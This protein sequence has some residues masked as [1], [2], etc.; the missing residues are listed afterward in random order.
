M[1][2][3]LMG[4]DLGGK[5]G[6]CL[7]L[8]VESG[9]AV[10]TC[11][12]WQQ[13][14]TAGF[15]YDLDT[16]EVWRF[17]GEAAR[18]AM[19]KV[20]ARLQDVLAVSTTGMRHGS[21]V[22]DAGGEVLLA[23]QTRDVR[24]AMHGLQLAAERG[25]EFHQRTGHFPAPLFTTS[26]LLWMA[27]S[28][29]ELLGRA[30]A[31]LG[32]SDWL[33]YRLSGKIVAEPS[34]AS[35][36]GLFE[37]GA[38]RWADD[39]IRSLGLPRQL[40]P[41]VVSSGTV[42]GPLGKDAAA[43]LGLQPGIPVV[44]G[45]GDTQCGLLGAGVVDSGQM[46]I[47]AGS[48][49][50]LQWVLE[51][52]FIDT[53]ARLWTSHHVVQ[54]RWTIESNGGPSGDMIDWLAGVIYLGLGDPAAALFAEA[55]QSVVGAEGIVST[56]GAEVFD[57]SRLRLPI[58]HLTLSPL[59]VADDPSRRRHLSRA[60]V[61]GLA[62][63]V[64]GNLELLQKAAQN[65]YAQSIRLAGGMSK[66]AFFAQLLSDVLGVPVEAAQVPECS[67]LGAAICAGVGARL[68][69]NVVEGARRFACGLRGFAPDS[70]RHAAY[71]LYYDRWL[72]VRAARQRADEL[73]ESNAIEAIMAKAAENTAR[74]A[75]KIS[76]PRPNI[77]VT[78][79]M[80]E[81]GL[82][83]LR[84][85]GEVRY[86][87]FRENLRLLAGED[88]VEA[89]AG[90]QVFITEVDAVDAEVLS[91]A[92]DLR[93]VASCRGNAV[94]LDIDACTAHG[95]LVLTTPARNADAVADL[96][97]SFML[98]LARKLPQATQFLYQPG[99]AGDV[100]R[101]GR[102]FEGLKGHELWHKTIGIV[103]LGAVGQ[104]VA[105]RLQPFGVRFI[106]YDPFLSLEKAVLLDVESVSLEQLLV[107]SD[108]VTLHAAVTDESR[109][110]LGP[111]EIAKMKRGAYLINTARAALVDQAALVSALK[112]GRLAGAAVDVFP[113]EPPSS[114][115]PL[116]HLANVIATPHVGGNTFEVFSHQGAIVA[117]DLAELLRGKQPRH[118]ANRETLEHFSWTAPRPVPSPEIL[119][120]LRQNSRPSVTDLPVDGEKTSSAPKTLPVLLTEA[121]RVAKKEGLLSGLKNVFLGRRSEK[122]E[123][124][125]MSERES[126]NGQPNPHQNGSGSGGTKELR[127]QMEQLLGA[128]G[129]RVSRD[130]KILS[131]AEGRQV[132]VRY[133]LNDVN[134]SFYTSFDQ[135]AVRCGVGDPPEKPE[136][137]LKMKADILDKLFTGREN[138][139][140]AAMSGKL[141]FTG[142]TIKAMSLQRIQKDLNR[143]YTEARAEIK[144]LDAIFERAANETPAQGNPP[145]VAAPSGEV[146]S[147]GPILV[148]DIRDEVI[149]TVE[150]MYRHGLITSTGGNASVRIPGKDEVWITPNSS[151]KGA[152]RPDMLV[153]VDLEGNPM[154]D[155]PY[156]PSSER[157][158]HCTVY[159][160]SPNVGAVIHSHAPKATILGLAG[161]PFL[162]I[163]T[164]AAFI[165]EIP[166]VPFIMPGTVELADAVGAAAKD[167]P[168]VIMQNHGLIVGGQN[169]RH[170]IDM[171]LIIEQTA[172]KLIACHM[173]GKPPPVLPDEIVTTLKNLGEMV[174]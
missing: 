84:Q 56:L 18:E 15:G 57:A 113:I 99:E 8:D 28:A 112:D 31:V 58:G 14:M 55:S 125:A 104:R 110:L 171:T 121:S 120:R 50:P 90:V 170:A 144:D 43:H 168:A 25:R 118:V 71:Q 32:L 82:A 17:L 63:A 111:A 33:A 119:E 103:G 41:E 34:V 86:E 76:A 7:L 38:R 91:K 62:F 61:E 134:L 163:S 93:V 54:G 135:G 94:N 130:E 74:D 157:M 40:F 147:A 100:G 169:L 106:A 72:E 166:R 68:Y 154:G 141:S 81:E 89:L 123:T 136:V 146:A 39:L 13:R 162:P 109:A 161:L 116:L 172:D 19:A 9:E 129:R 64:K 102:A 79:A 105:K 11:R 78:A 23:T 66:S 70:A 138:G 101:M 45:G 158:L 92:P 128:F 153:R 73:A 124:T 167:A 20:G 139:P 51:R 26:R 96:T 137:T 114:D 122:I 69:G 151:F 107:E 88:L 42:L 6:R 21:V 133:V 37:V 143:L 10:S 36:S 165:G 22:I 156:A 53:E 35:E 131:F 115:H 174:A 126:R 159:R 87:S 12:P 49:M 30:H 148:G 2:Q 142:D 150:E 152:L 108:F 77:L 48:T 160:N 95:V 97:V 83:A 47:I 24:G 44:T 65:G 27:D 117:T 60:V 3:Y 155:S 59:M 127:G 149:R 16:V 29:P 145:P 173:L 164:E 4:L 75:S 98:M 140:K 67:A 1:A 52:E 85:L 80:D 46:G 132:T 5:K